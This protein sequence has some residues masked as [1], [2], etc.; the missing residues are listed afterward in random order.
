MLTL[1]LLVVRNESS[2]ATRGALDHVT[3][4]WRSEIADMNLY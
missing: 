2:E 3:I 4:E 1:P